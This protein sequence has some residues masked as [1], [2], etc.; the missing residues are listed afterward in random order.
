MRQWQW[1]WQV[2]LR[3]LVDADWK[4]TELQDCAPERDGAVDS[5]GATHLNGTRKQEAVYISHTM[6]ELGFGKLH[7]SVP[8]FDDN[9]GALHTA[10]N[11]TYSSRTKLIALHFFD[12]KE[13]VKGR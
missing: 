6:A 8:L 7:E 2:N 4:T 9:A 11:S 10:G 1:Q 12:L 13:I 5:G 3:L